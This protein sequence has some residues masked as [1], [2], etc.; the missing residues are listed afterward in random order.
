[1][2]LEPKLAALRAYL[3]KNLPP[4]VLKVMDDHMA[5]LRTGGAMNNV[6]KVGAKAPTF[7]LINQ[8]G[9]LVS[10]SA[11]L[12]KGPLVISFTRGAWCPFCA[13]D[14]KA[15][16]TIVADIRAAGFDLV[17][18]SPQSRER[19]VAQGKEMNLDM[20]LLAD[21]DNHAGIAFGLVYTFPEELKAVYRDVFKLDIAAINDSNVWQ[22]PMAARFVIAQD[23]TVLD[24]KVDP[25]YR[26]RPEPDDA[27]AL[28][29]S[30]PH[31]PA[32]VDALQQ[33]V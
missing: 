5:M 24:V 14:I 29:Q 21:Q 31:V 12:K 20:H 27:L 2:Q 3:D 30:H 22:L 25:D 16:N 1:M 8:H 18:L 7:S 32:L 33:H 9:D 10:S 23:G 15:Q 19:T 13:E 26:F 28:V 17:V 6:I 11:L 4:K